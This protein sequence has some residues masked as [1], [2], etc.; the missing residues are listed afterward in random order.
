MRFLPPPALDAA[1]GM[2]ERLA[3][4]A[5]LP[6]RA[7]LGADGLRL[8]RWRTAL[9]DQLAGAPG[10]EVPPRRSHGPGA[11]RG[12]RPASSRG[13]SCSRARAAGPSRSR[14]WSA[15]SA[16]T[17]DGA[18]RSRGWRHACSRRRRSEHRGLPAV[19]AVRAALDRLA[20]PIRD[21]LVLAGARRWTAADPEPCARRLAG[22]AQWSDPRGGEAAGPARCWRRLERALAFAAGGHTAGEALLVRRLADG[23]R[24]ESWRAG[25]LGCRRPRRAGT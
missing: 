23:G 5:A 18:R 12:R 21:R 6:G 13:S 1:L 8:W 11:G 25:P 3:R 17:A 10:M 4:K 22:T 2:N 15:G 14:R 19:A 20:G 24:G 7:G 16:A 9:A